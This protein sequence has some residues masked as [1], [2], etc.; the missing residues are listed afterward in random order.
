[1]ID[2][3]KKG[4]EK[5]ILLSPDFLNNSE[6]NIEDSFDLKQAN[7][8]ANPLIKTVNNQGNKLNK[9]SVKIL[10]TYNE[11]SSKKTI[12]DFVSQYNNRYFQLQSLLRNRQ[13]LQG[14]TT[15]RKINSMNENERVFFIGMVFDKKLTKN[16]NL[17]FTFEDKTG[18]LKAVITQKNKE[19]FD[20]AKDVTLDEVVGIEGFKG[21][22]I[23]FINSI[24]TPD[25]PLNKELKKSPNDDA[26]LFISDIHIGAK[27]FLKEGFEK[28]IQ[29]INGEIGSEEQK[30]IVKKI[31]YIFIIGD[32]V[33]GIGIFPGQQNDLE[34]EDIYDQYKEFTKYISRI[35]NDKTIII[36]PGNHDS[37]RIAEPQP[38]ISKEYL[39]ELHEKTNIIFVSSPSFINIGSNEEFIGF[40]ILIYHGYSFP[41]Y[42]SNIESLRTSGGLEA[43][44]N[45]MEYLLKKRHLA[46]T[47]GST[48]FQLGYDEDPLVIKDLPD[49]FVTGHIHRAAIRNYRNITLL[50]CSCWVS[51]TDYQEKRGMV[52]QPCRAIYVDLKTRESKIINFND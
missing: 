14:I 30:K 6:V 51:Q 28:L 2:L 37:V 47:H 43:T 18:I 9:T 48:R 3:V 19:L 13:E 17:M 26:A 34:I 39:P 33:E 38:I 12:K 21:K 7:I 36:C 22:G 50:N 10:K 31:K 4:L 49:F 23:V 42:A 16:N 5:G 11:K 52:P 27:A 8:V 24:I 25:V 20:I 35:P 46:P 15:I 1:M 29:W 45:I 40:D 44:E 32:L 41:Y